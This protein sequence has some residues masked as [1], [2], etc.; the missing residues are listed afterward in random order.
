MAIVC[1]PD[2]DRF[3]QQLRQGDD[4]EPLRLEPGQYFRH[5]FQ[6]FPGGRRPR[7]TYIMQDNDVIGADLPQDT[8]GH[9]PD[10]PVPAIPGPAG[11]IDTEQTLSTQN[12]T[13]LRIGNAHGGPE[14]QGDNAEGTQSGLRF[15]HFP[16][17]PFL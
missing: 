17:Q 10:E 11:K 8:A 6:P 15:H 5:F 1:S 3:P 13:E 14:R 4:Q 2:H 9:S 7:W 16:S 12:G